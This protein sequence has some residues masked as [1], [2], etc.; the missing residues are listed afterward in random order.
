MK[1]EVLCALRSTDGYVS[2]QQLCEQ[3]GVSRTAIWKAIQSLKEEGYVIDAVSNRG[4]KVISTP[5]TISGDEIGSRLQTSRMGRKIY[6]FESTGSTNQ[7]AKQVGEEGAPDGTLI[8]AEEQT[9]GRG[10]S[11]RK[12][13]TPPRCAIAF[14]LLLRPTLPP[15]RISMTTL[16]MGLA[17]E[18][19]VR[20]RYDLAVGIKWP[21]D[22]VI[23]GKKIC[24]IL[25]EMSAEMDGVHYI[26]IGTGINANLTS[27]PEE[28]RDVAT[29]L[30]IQLGHPVD[31][32]AL[33]TQ[34]LEEF[35][36]YYGIFEEDGDLRR[37][38]ETYNQDLLSRDQ[39]VRVLD[40]KG[41][42]TGTAL[43]IDKE[44]QLLVRRDDSGEVTKVWSGEVSVRG[45]YGYV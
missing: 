8:L 20:K 39:K 26:V 31:R 37:L 11:G 9:A 16:V 34:V 1:S 19:A 41:E 45:I 10:R 32:A 21:N 40:P 7:V 22:V 3:L 18:Q 35:E 43:G 33:L 4:Y 14:S 2:G 25:T 15:Q 6:F 27:F 42:Y 44:G 30:Q 28:I 29:S 38:Q 23:D 36:T 13:V 5:D 24:G 12:W 17:V